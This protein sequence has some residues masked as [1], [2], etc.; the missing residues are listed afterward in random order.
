MSGAYLSAGAGSLN[1]RMGRMDNNKP[2]MSAPA[3]NSNRSWLGRIQNI[4]GWQKTSGSTQGGISGFGERSCR[5]QRKKCDTNV[6]GHGWIDGSLD[7]CRDASRRADA[8]AAKQ[9]KAV[10]EA[11]SAIDRLATDMNIALDDGI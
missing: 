6:D 2:S 7:S 3:Y 9:M 4:F 10:R 1:G 5:N 11:K 8:S